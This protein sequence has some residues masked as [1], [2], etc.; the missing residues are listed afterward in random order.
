MTD[1]ALVQSEPVK[2]FVRALTI[3]SCLLS[4]C[5]IFELRAHGGG[6]EKAI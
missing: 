3:K 4:G 5:V 1:A 2:R 6:F